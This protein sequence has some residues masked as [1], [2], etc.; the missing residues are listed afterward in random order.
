[1][2]EI[3]ALTSVCPF[4]YGQMAC[5]LGSKTLEILSTPNLALSC[6]NLLYLATI[7]ISCDIF[8]NTFLPNNLF[9]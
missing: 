6:Y 1:M 3:I 9:I 8:K 7:S 2:Y 5:M 4:I